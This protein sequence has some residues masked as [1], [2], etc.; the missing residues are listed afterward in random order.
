MATQSYR[1]LPLEKGLAASYRKE[2]PY[3][4]L[5]VS[6]NKTISTFTDN[7][8]TNAWYYLAVQEA[9]N[10]HYNTSKENSAYEKWTELRKTLD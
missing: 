3:S 2:I 1:A 10:S 5:Y 7:A 6:Y 4:S 8:D 9:T